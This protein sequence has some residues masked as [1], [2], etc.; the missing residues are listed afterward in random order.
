M[1][2]GLETSDGGE[3]YHALARSPAFDSDNGARP[4]RA[5]LGQKARRRSALRAASNPKP[6]S[7]SAALRLE[8]EDGGKT[9]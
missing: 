8:R 1:F 3:R 5:P 2:G 6:T 9:V 4:P 7:F